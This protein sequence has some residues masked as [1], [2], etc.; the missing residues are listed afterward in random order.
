[1]QRHEGTLGIPI[2]SRH[3]RSDADPRPRSMGSRAVLAGCSLEV[4]FFGALRPD[5]KGLTGLALF[6]VAGGDAF[7]EIG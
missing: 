4:A 3:S 6:V 5:S 1:M 2:R 7:D